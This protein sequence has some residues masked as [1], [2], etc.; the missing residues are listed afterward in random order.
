ML[1]SSVAISHFTRSFRCTFFF[2][3]NICSGPKLCPSFFETVVL[4][5]LN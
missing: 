1:I 2:L 4:R 5:G 3:L